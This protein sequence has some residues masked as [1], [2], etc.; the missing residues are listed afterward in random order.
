MLDS[1]FGGFFTLNNT[2]RL[3]KETIRFLSVL[4]YP[5]CFIEYNCPP[6]V[7]VYKMN[8]RLVNNTTGPPRV[9]MN[10]LKTACEAT[11]LSLFLHPETVP[12]CGQQSGAYTARGLGGRGDSPILPLVGGGDGR[13]SLRRTFLT[14]SFFLLLLY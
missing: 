2:T 14:F 9:V 8:N 12:I 7:D 10:E 6:K 4:V 11:I 1:D 5:F 13:I 3:E